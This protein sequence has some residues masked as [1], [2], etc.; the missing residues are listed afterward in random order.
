MFFRNHER[1]R[2]L[3]RTKE[4]V[5]LDEG[6]VKTR[7]GAPALFRLAG[8]WHLGREARG[9]DTEIN[10]CVYDNS[11]DERADGNYH[12]FQFESMH[13]VGPLLTG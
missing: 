6:Y 8:G 13:S 11:R 10:G 1:A 2:Y 12:H 4:R 9:V 3:D 7:R 5:N